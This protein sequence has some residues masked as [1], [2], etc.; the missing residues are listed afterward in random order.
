MKPCLYISLALIA[1]SALLGYV[2]YHDDLTLSWSVVMAPVWLPVAV[3]GLFIAVLSLWESIYF[4]L[5]KRRA[6]KAL[7]EQEKE[8]HK[9][10]SILD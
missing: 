4:A 1:S 9:I 6:Y 5:Q 2:K 10:F 7:R 3:L 8:R